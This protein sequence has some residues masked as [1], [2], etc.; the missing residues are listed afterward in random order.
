MSGQ[1]YT[2]LARATPDYFHGRKYYG[3]TFPDIP[4]SY[5]EADNLHQMQDFGR[6]VL[7]IYLANIKINKKATPEPR[8][9]RRNDL[10]RDG[11]IAITISQ[12]DLEA[13]IKELSARKHK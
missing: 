13:K 8:Y 3:V 11:Q 12:A 9:R 2:Y 10:K 1:S 5:F 4:D 7:A 6:D